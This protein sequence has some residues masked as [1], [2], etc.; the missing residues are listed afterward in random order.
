M[1][2]KLP[3]YRDLVNQPVTLGIGWTETKITWYLPGMQVYQVDRIGSRPPN[4]QHS[5]LIDRNGFDT[6]VRPT[7]VRVGFGILTLLDGWDPNRP[8]W[9]QQPISKP[10]VYLSN[11]PN[12]YANPF[13]TL[14]TPSKYGPFATLTQDD[15][16]DSNSLSTSR[17]FNNQGIRG[18][19]NTQGVKMHINY[20]LTCYR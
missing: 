11:V 17:I 1:L 10:L 20:L 12:L 8:E 16:V 6:L 2:P 7:R 19:I 18:T 15:F 3:V 9:N 5:V 14:P 4:H 13:V